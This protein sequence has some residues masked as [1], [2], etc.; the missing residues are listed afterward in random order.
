MFKPGNDHGSL[1]MP[2]VVFALASTESIDL[3]L[4]DFSRGVPVTGHRKRAGV[5]AD[6][7]RR[8][9]QRQDKR[10]EFLRTASLQ[11]DACDLELLFGIN[12]D[13]LQRCINSCSSH[14]TIP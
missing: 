14:S 5:A 11:R 8:V 7:V 4:N 3:V 6:P 2:V 1:S 10:R 13:E 12:Q 9:N